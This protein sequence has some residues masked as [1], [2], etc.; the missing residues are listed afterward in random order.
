MQWHYV[1]QRGQRTAL[2]TCGFE[3]HADRIQ[4]PA[5]TKAKANANVRMMMNTNNPSENIDRLDDELWDD[6]P[7]SPDEEAELTGLLD[8]AMAVE[9]DQAYDKIGDRLE[10][11]VLAATLPELRQ[12]SEV[13]DAEQQP[14][15]HVIARIGSDSWGVSAFRLAAM[16]MLAALLGLL[17]WSSVVESPVNQMAENDQMI[18]PDGHEAVSVA[19]LEAEF[20]AD[21]GVDLVASNDDSSH[22]DSSVAE[23]SVLGTD[24]SGLATELAALEADLNILAMQWSDEASLFDDVLSED[25]TELWESSDFFDARTF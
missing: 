22:D 13:Q 7:L 14:S 24:A 23:Q 15:S 25:A 11:N 10:A 12:V 4:H 20:A 3:R 17:V 1:N 6:Q 19:T 9:I 18:D 2:E 16:L 21:W 8:Q 5:N